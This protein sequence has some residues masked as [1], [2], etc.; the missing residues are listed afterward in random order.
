MSYLFQ[1]VD[2]RTVFDKITSKTT[3]RSWGY[4][5]LSDDLTC[6]ITSLTGLIAFNV[7]GVPIY[8]LVSLSSTLYRNISTML[9][10]C[11][12]KSHENSKFSYQ[13]ATYMKFGSTVLKKLS[14]NSKKLILFVSFLK[15][16]S[17]KVFLFSIANQ[18][19]QNKIVSCFW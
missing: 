9:V 1:H 10:Q 18:K 2:Q 15:H 17:I 8:K 5:F 12:C 6:A 3:W 19:S 16:F 4:V 13:G 7:S 11:S 14:M